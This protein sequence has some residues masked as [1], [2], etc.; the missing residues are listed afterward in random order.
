MAT[1]T[2]KPCEF[3]GSPK[4]VMLWVILSQAADPAEGATTIPEGSRT[5]ASPK[6]TALSKVT[7]D[8]MVSPRMKVRAAFKGGFQVAFGNEDKRQEG[9]AIPVG[10]LSIGSKIINRYKLAEI[11]VTT[12]ELKDRSVVDIEALFRRAI[13]RAYA[14]VLDNAFLS[15]TASTAGVRPA[16]ILNGITVIAGDNTGGVASVTADLQAMTAELLAVNES[17]VPV[18]AI[19]NRN[20]MGLGFLTSALGEFLFR[21]EI[22][23]GR[24][25][26]VP[27]V[28]SGNVPYNTAVM[29]D[30]SSLAMALG[31][32]EFDV[33]QTATVVMNNA[34]G[35]I[36]T[37]ADDGSAGG[38]VG[39]AGQVHAGQGVVPAN[40]AGAGYHARSLWQTYSEGVRMIAPTSWMV[41]RAGSVAGRNT[42]AW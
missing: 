40:T 1:S 18:L 33:S 11:L 23:S 35:T 30:V 16:G 27:I 20:R 13:E 17:A 25:L 4:Q 29:V 8:D 22:N 38:A 28:S 36:P 2:E 39:T 12:M 34:D 19:N 24:V 32:P 15:A 14:K 5:Q 21:D 26:G 6:R 10:S 41:M 31:T 3:R 42:L 9:G 7:G 37:M